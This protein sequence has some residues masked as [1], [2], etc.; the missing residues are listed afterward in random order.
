MSAIS[1]TPNPASF[2]TTGL[3]DPSL[4]TN[5][6]LTA[7]IAGK[8]ANTALLGEL[9]DAAAKMMLTKSAP[10]GDEVSDKRGA[11]AIPQ[12]ST[13]ISSDDMVALLRSIRSKSQDAQL[14]AAK[15]GVETARIKAE[16]NTEGQLKKIEEWV[17]K[18]E[19]AAAK[20]KAG[21]IFGWISKIVAV[22]AAVVAVVASGALSVLSGGA[23][24]PLMALA[25]MALVGT[26][27]ALA[28][29]ISKEVGGPGI[30]IAGAL[31]QMTAKFLEACGVDK[32]MAGKIGTLVA[33]AIGCATGLVLAEPGLAASMA[34]GICQLAGADDAV[35]GY[36]AM[37][38]GM[39]AAI[40]I[41]V[42]TV[43]ASG[44][45][46]AASTA[47][48]IAGA[49]AQFVQGAAGVGA[50]TVTMLKAGDEKA[51]QGALAG[52]A[53]L[54]AEMVKLQAAQEDGR[55]EIK[56]IIQQIED[57]LAAVSKM[58]NDSADSMS[59]ITANMGK[60]MAV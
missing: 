53:E 48:K 26:T 51:A 58:I 23:A 28:D 3:P 12:P 6:G 37:A 8:L 54:A 38:V 2:A 1:S 7:G 33:G 34:T 52:K 16:K 41:G 21:G 11:P 40:T 17:K 9:A 56:K 29:Q 44:G 55:E 46:S 10:G 13:S 60:R 57:G 22:I 42:V 35:T 20:S 24:T 43:V 49:S 47:S 31:T 18:C 39:A 59:Q 36:V 4:A 50:G 45:A 15:G 19:E 5:P 25:M 27:L 14:E 32:E 30:S